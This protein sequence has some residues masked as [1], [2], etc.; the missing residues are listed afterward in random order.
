[1]NSGKRR[2]AMGCPKRLLFQ[3][4]FLYKIIDQVIQRDLFI[5]QLEVT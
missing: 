3:R 2:K 1:M 4:N 5:P